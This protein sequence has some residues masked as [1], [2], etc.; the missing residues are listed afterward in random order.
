VKCRKCGERA[1]I[2]MRQ[3]KLALC[4]THFLEWI[5]G[6]T[7]RA[8]E[9]YRM[10]TRQEKILVAV[11]GGKDSLSLW[12]VLKGL[13]YAADGIYIDLGIDAGI[14]YSAKSRALCEQ[15]AAAGG[16]TLHVVSVP[17]QY[18]ASITEAAQKSHRGQSKPCSVCG[19]VK[20]HI[21]NRIARDGGYGVLLTGHN[22]DDEAAVLLHN[23]MTWS[24]GYLARQAP[25]LPASPLGLA[26]KAKPFCRIYERETAAYAVMRGIEYIYDECPFADGSTTIYYKEILNRMEEDRPGAK[27]QFYLSFL[28][29]KEQGLFAVG[30]SGEEQL[31]ECERCGQPTT[32]P[33]LCT[34]C[35]LWDKVGSSAE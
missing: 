13:G 21:M 20:R 4:R 6:Q 3:H 17:A 14:G 31:H 8:I 26:R 19:L 7:E 29:A 27:L 16:L 28:Q 33:G 2:N 12:D 32:A 9:H 30:A 1:A 25:V 10:F 11:S 23:A 24:G 15:F 18:G 34:F 22:L 5:P 35:R